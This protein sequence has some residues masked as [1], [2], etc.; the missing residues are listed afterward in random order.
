MRRVLILL[1]ALIAGLATLVL[2]E[3]R[4]PV[5]QA[6]AVQEAAD[7]IVKVLV[8]ARDLPRGTLVDEGALA[9]Q[10]QLR[11]AAPAEAIISIEPEPSFPQVLEG[12]LLR[13]DVLKGEALQLAILVD[14]AAGF[15][16]LTLNPG[17]RA[18][19]MSVT[20]QRLAGGFILPEDR[21]NILHTTSGDFDGDGRANTYSQ[22]ILENIR[23]LAVGSTPSGRITF[24]T[25]SQQ[26][27]ST[28]E[29]PPAVTMLGET[30]TLEMSDDEAAVLFSAMASGQISLALR[31][32]ED[33]GP[34]RIASVLG[35]EQTPADP[36]PNQ[37]L[38]MSTTPKVAEPAPTLRQE[39][40][41]SNTSQVRLI[42]TGTISF[43]EAP[44]HHTIEG[45]NSD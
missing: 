30:I 35:F 38:E 8:F 26:S 15:M 32:L 41:P 33:H 20:A 6:P 45:Q 37:P 36:D 21:V 5:P 31:A 23:V 17:M 3:Y 19:G 39:S 11:T 44:V 40:A 12:K 16:A 10:E 2:L 22:T 42:Q 9:W 1:F 4:R 28:A 14:G 34:S 27:Q 25:A 43:V 13:R 7:E 18:V 29:Q 24:Q